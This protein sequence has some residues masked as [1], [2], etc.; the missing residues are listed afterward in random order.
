[1][2]KWF[3]R[4]L[5]AVVVLMALTGVSQAAQVNGSLPFAIFG[6]SQNG[7]DLS[8]STLI[9]GTSTPTSNTG[10]GD[11]SVIGSGVNFGLFALDLTNLPAFSLTNAIYGSFDASSGVVLQKNKNFLDVYLL[12]VF[13]PVSGALPGDPSAGPTSLRISINQ[14]GT[15]LGGG[16]TLSSPPLGAPEPVSMILLGSGLVAFGLIRRKRTV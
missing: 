1:M 6:L 11:Y 13:T 9:N 15:S 10:T 2:Q 5:P 12:G 3:I 16:I 14:S 7:A 8:V 4:L